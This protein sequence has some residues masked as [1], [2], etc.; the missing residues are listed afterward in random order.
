M[1]RLALVIFLSAAAFARADVTYN[2]LV[3]TPWQDCYVTPC[4][5]FNVPIPQFD[6]SQGTLLSVS[7][8][9]LDSQTYEGGYN[10]EQTTPGQ[11]FSWTTTEGDVSALLGLDASNTQNNSAITCA[12]WLASLQPPN[13]NLITASGTVPDDSPF[14]GTGTV[15]IPVTPFISTSLPVA[16]SLGE[17]IYG[18]IGPVMDGVNLTVTYV[19]AT[20]PL[21]LI[22]VPEPRWTAIPAAALLL[23]SLRV[24]KTRPT[25][26]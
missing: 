11:S 13:V 6:P 1:K 19:T 9:F 15:E 8:T 20:D 7:W 25:H 21:A 3:G 2:V 10:D 4:S 14:I 12:C 18:D 17:Y 24:F 26:F 16:D 5:A 22:E 23:V